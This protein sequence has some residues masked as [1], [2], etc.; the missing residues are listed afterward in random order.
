MLG[1]INVGYFVT[2]IAVYI[3]LT[4]IAIIFN[5]EKDDKLLFRLERIIIIVLMLVSLIP[6]AKTVKQE[7]A[8]FNWRS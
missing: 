1:V 6:T 4:N 3:P 5:E 8:D 2:V 7:Y